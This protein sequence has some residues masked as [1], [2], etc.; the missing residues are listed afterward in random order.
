MRSTWGTGV[1][2]ELDFEKVN[3]LKIIRTFELQGY[4]VGT[5][6]GTLQLHY[7]TG[8]AGNPDPL[9]LGGSASGATWTSIGSGVCGRWSEDVPVGDALLCKRLFLRV[10]CTP[11][12]TGFPVL[13][14]AIAF[15]ATM[16]PTN[17]TF[18]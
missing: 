9:S 17:E 7:M 10:T 2:S 11:S 8:C 13:Q 12:S 6:P 1:S 3:V 16:M 5:S 4:F 15:G 14:A 18:P